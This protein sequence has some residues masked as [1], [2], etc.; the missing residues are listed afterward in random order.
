MESKSAFLCTSSLP[1]VSCHNLASMTVSWMLA[2]KLPKDIIQSL[3][4]C[5]KRF[6]C[7]EENGASKWLHLVAWLYEGEQERVEWIVMSSAVGTEL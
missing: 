5:F 6:L 4:N 2:L 1:N 7:L 3:E